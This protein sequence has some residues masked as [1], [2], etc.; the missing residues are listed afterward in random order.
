MAACGGHCTR[1][2]QVPEFQS[3]K[4]PEFQSSEVR[5]FES[6]KVRVHGSRFAFT[7]LN[8]ELWNLGTLELWNF[9]T[10]LLHGARRFSH[11]TFELGAAG[12]VSLPSIIRCM[13]RVRSVGRN[14][15][16]K[17]GVAKATGTARY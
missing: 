10:L 14:V 7:K 1:G 2:F 8:H 5:E 12:H 15:L 6:P 9:G 3:S 16:R 13:R 11:G 4:V 17:E